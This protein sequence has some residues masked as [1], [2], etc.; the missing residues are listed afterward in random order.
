M[1][2]LQI[3]RS[4]L[5][6]FVGYPLQEVWPLSEN[7]I[8]LNFHLFLHM[9]TQIERKKID[10]FTLPE[11]L[12]YTLPHGSVASLKISVKLTSERD[13]FLL[14]TEQLEINLPSV[15]GET[16]KNNNEMIKYII[17]LLRIKQ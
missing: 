11:K 17:I 13:E 12:T 16:F 7:I 4:I 14:E 15:S 10:Q 6:N 5:V 8:L 1:L 2:F 9:L 3:M